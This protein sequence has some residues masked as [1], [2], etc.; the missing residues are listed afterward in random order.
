MAIQDV[1]RWHW[2]VIALGLG[3]AFGASRVMWQI[4]FAQGIGP[5]LSQREL[6]TTTED[7]GP[8]LAQMVIHPPDADGRSWVVVRRMVDIAQG[9]RAER[10]RFAAADPY[11]PLELPGGNSALSIEGYLRKVNAI[12][13]ESHFTYR[14]AWWER[15]WYALSLGA[16][17]GLLAM[18]IIWRVL[19]QMMAGAGLAGAQEKLAYDLDRFGRSS[20]AL[21]P[22]DALE[23]RQHNDSLNEYVEAMLDSQASEPLQ[24]AAEMR[25][26][27]QGDATRSTPSL[28]GG[29]L[30]PLQV[31]PES[32]KDYQGEYYPVARRTAASGRQEPKSADDLG[33]QA[34]G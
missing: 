33:T 12:H 5:V 28:K 22:V 34:A 24:A 27:E 19:L 7:G 2:A 3:L 16:G 18:G 13:P 6:L 4:D 31:A 26:A 29:P 10:F 14:Y 17:G 30:N 32:P 20:A 11:R 8:R 9:E 21:A 25:S 23:D 15:T 1:K